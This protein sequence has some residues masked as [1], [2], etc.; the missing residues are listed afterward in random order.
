M[1]AVNFS[2]SQIPKRK[3]RTF[4]LALAELDRHHTQ[5]RDDKQSQYGGARQAPK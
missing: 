2:T 1:S 4:S 3:S 5:R